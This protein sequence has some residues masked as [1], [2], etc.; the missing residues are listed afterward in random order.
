MRDQCQGKV[1]KHTVFQHQSAE[2]A[3]E[4]NLI[5][6]EMVQKHSAEALAT[7]TSAAD[8]V[9]EISSDLTRGES[10]FT[11]PYD[12]SSTTLEEKSMQRL[13]TAFARTLSSIPSYSQTKRDKIM[14]DSHLKFVV[15]GDGGIGKTCLLIS[16]VQREFPTEYVPTVFENYVT[17]I[18]GPKRKIIELALWDTA[19]QEEYNRLR[20]LSY[21]EVDI[22]MVCYAVNSKIS[23]QNVEDL[24]MPEVKHFCPDTPVILV[25]LKSDLLSQ[26]NAEERVDRNKADLVAKKLGA[27]AHIQCSAKLQN[28]VDEVF[29]AALNTALRD[30]LN[31][32][33][34]LTP[35]IK[36]AFKKRSTA[37]N[38]PIAPSKV[39]TTSKKT[40]HRKFNCTII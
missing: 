2:V 34:D 35:L 12:G 18:E 9:S 14:A 39:A 30:R 24:W 8:Q 16:Y 17:K 13:P 25:G 29:N 4:A 7:P 5:S 32:P 1:T 21:S 19:G 28:D 38:R 20:P 23:L 3:D 27:F 31:E 10:A 40:P 26:R 36:N 6:W 11:A 33:K 15:V 22:L 37:P